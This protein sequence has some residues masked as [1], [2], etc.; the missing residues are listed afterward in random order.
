MKFVLILLAIALIVSCS[1]DR[2]R[3]ERRCGSRLF[4]MLK[5]ICKFDL[6]P[7]DVKASELCCL[8]H[9]SYETMRK[10]FCKKQPK[11]T[12]NM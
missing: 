3:F 1:V 11:R 8:N 5:K 4:N 9:C 12:I 10:V 6:Q 7:I 2:V